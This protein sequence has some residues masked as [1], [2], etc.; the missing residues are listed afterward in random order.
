MQR[1]EF[2]SLLGS[3]AAA[4]PLAARA[5]QAGMPVVG[6]IVTPS[7]EEWADRVEEFRR[8]LAEAGFVEGRNVAIEFR[9]VDNQ[10]DRLPA[11]VA[12]LVGRKV[13][14]FFVTGDSV[15]AVPMLKAATRIIPIVFTTGSDP[16]ARGMVE[17]LNRP[18]G[19]VTGATSISTELGPKYLE[20]L[21]EIIPD[22]TRIGLLVNPKNPAGTEGLV[23]LM[24][25]AADRLGVETV[26]REAGTVEEIDQVFAT[27]ARQGIAALV[28]GQDAF[29]LARREQIAAL[30]LNY[31]MATVSSARQFSEA[32]GLIS[33]GSSEDPARQAG[34]YIGRILKGANPGELPIM[35]PAKFV[36]II[37]LKTAKALGLTVP[38]SF[39]L[40]ADEV[41]E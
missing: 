10:L 19:N 39:L 13:A 4:W 23:Q 29:F 21:H 7:R 9:Y 30:A 26:I 37:N 16:V 36:M 3:A 24:Q 38:Q 41:I 27:F 28:V 14:A 25:P 8:G 32:G 18:G 1:R 31:R 11:I 17:S 22:V 2:I 40:R 34:V 15:V 5:Q 35:Q 33:Y 12:D 20:M 6:A